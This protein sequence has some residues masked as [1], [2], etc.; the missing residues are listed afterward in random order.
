MIEIRDLE[1]Q[2]YSDALE[3]Q[4]SLNGK[5]KQIKR[6]GGINENEFLLLVEHP[7][8]YTLGKHADEFNLLVPENILA[9]EGIELHHINRGGDITYHGPG[10]L[11]AYPIIDLERHHLG[12]KAYVSLLE[13]AV[14][15]TI[16]EFGIKGVRD[17]GAT[18]V[19]LNDDMGLRKICAIGVSISRSVTM[20]GLALNVNTDLSYFHRI[21]P[22]GFTDRGVTSI[23]RELGH[24]VDMDKVKN[25]FTEKFTSLLK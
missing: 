24:K 7:H 4:V 1:T 19:W 14:I 11:V 21:N 8:V 16:A 13:Q 5:M 20:H 17:D 18:G 3:L 23:A 12:V 22:C 6:Q 2:S 10:Q 25:I 15:D 9:A